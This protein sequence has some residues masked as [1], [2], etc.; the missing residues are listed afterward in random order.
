MSK[1]LI[2]VENLSFAYDV[3]RIIEGANF[4]IHRNDVIT[5]V[6]PN[7]GGKTTLLKLLM[8]QLKPQQGF[9][10][11]HVDNPRLFGYVP[12]Y[13]NLD[14]A[15]PITVF[16]VVLSGRIKN[17]GFYGRADREAA[18]LSLSEVGLEALGKKSFF[19]LSGGQRQRVLIARALASRPEILILDEPTANIDSEAE[20]SLNLLL[21]RLSADHTIILVTHD[22]GF[23]DDM[24]N[25]VLCVNRSV[26]EHPLDSLDDGLIAAAYGRPVK[27][28][29][30]DHNLD[31][32]TYCGT[33][34][35]HE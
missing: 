30:H 34:H 21:K 2:E 4:H 20:K 26:R 8:G 7:G 31:V 12:Q 6:G 22:I 10:R 9:V 5:V 28:V 11:L 32:D 1:E 19:E 16:E 24:T 14:H 15:Y 3:E 35:V 27:L 18:E 17:F 29:R 23:V 25:R 33:E 13:S